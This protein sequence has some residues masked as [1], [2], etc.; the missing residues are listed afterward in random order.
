LIHKGL[1]GEAEKRCRDLETNL[2][3]KR[4]VGVKRKTTTRSKKLWA[5]LSVLLK[6]L[7]K[8]REGTQGGV[9]LRTAP[10]DKF[11]LQGE[12]EGVEGEI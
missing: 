11:R 1:E 9:R 12:M 7:I 4:I 10:T 3:G 5:Q 6:V 8:E 2:A